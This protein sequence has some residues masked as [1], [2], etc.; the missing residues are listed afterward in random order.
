MRLTPRRWTTRW[1]VLAATCIVALG[2]GATVIAVRLSGSSESSPGGSRTTAADSDPTAVCGFGGSLVDR[3]VATRPKDEQPADLSRWKVDGDGDLGGIAAYDDGVIVK[4]ATSDG[5]TRFL[6]F[7][8]T[9][10]ARSETV[11]DTEVGERWT[12]TDDGGIFYVDAAKS[13]TR[14]VVRLGA[15]G[16]RQDA[17]DVPRSA[18]TSDQTT[19]LGTMV[20]VRDYRGSGALLISEGS[21]TVQVLSASGQSLGMLAN[22]TDDVVARVTGSAVAGYRSTSSRV[23]ELDVVDVGTGAESLHTVY[24]ALSADASTNEGA[25]PG[26]PVPQELRGVVPGPGGDGFLLASRNGI[27]WVDGLGVQKGM[28]LAGQN[29]L[30]N[31]GPAGL[32]ERGGRYWVLGAKD[33]KGSDSVSVLSTAQ[34]R[35]RIEEPVLDTASTELATAQLGVGI[36]AVTRAPFN[37]F[38]APTSPQVLLRA[39]KG[40]GEIQGA[41][42]PALAVRYSIRGDPTLADPVVQA[43]R[44]A[45]IPWGGGETPLELPATRPGPYEVDLRLVDAGSGTVLSGQCLRYSVGSASAPLDLASV[46]PGDDWGG[47]SPLRGVQLAAELGVRSHR[48]Q[49]D[50]G[51][52]VPDPTSAPSVDAVRWDRLPAATDGSDPWAALREAGDWAVANDVRLIIQVGSGG[53]AERS[54]ISAG[55]WA[56]WAK[57]IVG[58]FAQNAPGITTWEAFN[59]PN[60][61]GLSPAEYWTAVEIPFADAAHAARADSFVIAGNT[62]GFAADWWKAAAAAGVCSRV[63]AIGVHPYTG[64]NR[65]WEEE[66]SER[67]GKGWGEVSAA[68]GAACSDLPR[69]DTESGWTADGSVA[70]WAQGSNVTRKLLWYQRERIAGWTYFFS[71]GGFGE[72]GL[73][74]SLVQYRAYVKP[75]GLAFPVATELLGGRGRAETVDSGIP[76]T[77]VMRVPGRDALMAAWTDEARLGARLSTSSASVSVTDAYGTTS[78]VPVKD[79]SADVTLTASPQFFRAKAGSNL[80]LTSSTPFGRDL[81]RGRKVSASSTYKDSDPQT[82]TSG[83]ADPFRPWR[84]GRGSSGIDPRPSVTIPLATTTTI[85]RIAVATTNI[86]CCEAGLRSYTVSIQKPDGSWTVVARPTRQFWERTVVF[87][88]DP[89][90][91]KA[92]RVR[93]QWTTIRG[94]RMLDMNYT[95]FAGGLPPPFMGL[96]TETDYVMSLYAVSAWA[97][98]TSR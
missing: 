17:F 59:E 92:V 21:R 52:L 63:D 68:L 98:A 91:A 54:A 46:A 62:L 37:H 36:G 19:D 44:T 96:Q 34:M 72:N 83:T 18:E 2:A 47:A 51:A 45:E 95:G 20:W 73:S 70:Y 39:E 90:E 1:I 48:V 22:G 33:D 12:V 61:A 31:A 24:S 97:P 93:A 94:V 56:G 71:E 77:H 8:A 11:V 15:D 9:G 14:R 25:T 4:R 69:W 75:G 74:W 7:S 16:S 81:L 43:T 50:F 76:F 87:R 80:R 23:T 40:W 30:S 5:R 35:E 32:V 60:N 67:S 66:G 79:G 6:R 82:I 42:R 64:W 57:V 41:T 85:D 86:A 58:A 49:L 55:T 38:P 84:S 89:A 29:G 26:T 53:D 78:A 88:F 27:Q 3:I 65:S 13:S 10:A 28:W